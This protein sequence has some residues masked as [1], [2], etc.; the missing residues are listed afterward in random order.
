MT[1]PPPE[2]AALERNADM[3][4]FELGDATVRPAELELAEIM[5]AMQLDDLRQLAADLAEESGNSEC[6]ARVRSVLKGVHHN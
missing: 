3:L 5:N 1:P 6:L 2:L 4:D